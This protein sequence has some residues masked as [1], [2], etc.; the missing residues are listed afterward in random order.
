MRKLD[1]ALI[2][3][4]EIIVKKLLIVCLVSE[5]ATHQQGVHGCNAIEKPEREIILALVPTLQLPVDGDGLVDAG[6]QPKNG[7]T[8]EGVSARHVICSSDN[9]C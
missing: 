6:Q 2:T 9:N 7:Q 5:R 8:G 4:G 1:E 3:W